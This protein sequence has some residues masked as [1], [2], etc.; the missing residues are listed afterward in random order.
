MRKLGLT[1]ADFVKPLPR[2]YSLV[3]AVLGRGARAAASA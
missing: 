2:P 3:A 1:E